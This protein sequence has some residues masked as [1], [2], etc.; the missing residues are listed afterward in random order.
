MLHSYIPSPNLE[1]L[2]TFARIGYVF[3]LVLMHSVLHITIAS[4]SSNLP[5]KLWEC[6]SCMLHY[7]CNQ[8]F[9][10]LPFSPSYYYY[11]YWILINEKL[12]RSHQIS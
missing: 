7:R 3:L 5:H 11:Y 8:G 1:N 12:L 10:I 6:K 4:R 2:F 9:I